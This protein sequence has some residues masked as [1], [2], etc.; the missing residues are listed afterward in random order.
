MKTRF[1]LRDL[2]LC[3][4][5][6]AVMALCAWI[7]VPAP[8]PFT[9]QSF[10]VFAALTVLG[11]KRGVWA[12]GAYLL[13]GAAGAPVFAGFRGGLG[14]FFGTTGGYLWGFLL[15]ALCYR[16]LTRK[17]TGTIRRGLALAVGQCL[18]YGAGM[19]WTALLHARADEPVTFWALFVTCVLP[20]L[21]PDAVKLWL[22]VTLG[23]TISTHLQKECSL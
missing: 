10:G 12:V 18:C 7:T 21:L 4:L 5:F 3:A 11:G 22:A 16:W 20:F 19:G 13:L 2:C 6:A 23:N 14:V 1:P 9:L 8:V 15:T 17:R